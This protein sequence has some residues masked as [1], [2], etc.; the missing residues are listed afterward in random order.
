MQRTVYGHL[1]SLC[2]W[3]ELLLDLSSLW[4]LG[5]MSGDSSHYVVVGQ[6]NRNAIVQSKKLAPFH[7]DLTR[8]NPFEPASVAPGQYTKIKL[9]MKHSTDRELILNDI[10][11][12][13]N[14]DFSARTTASVGNVF[15][16]RGT[17]LIREL[18]VKI[19]EDI[20]FKVDRKGD[21]TL[22]WLMNNH[23]HGGEEEAVN[24]S[25]LMNQGVIPAGYS[26][27]FFYKTADSGWYTDAA[28]TTQTLTLAEVTRPGLERHD[29]LPRLI[30][31]DQDSGN[32]YKFCFDM[33][34]NQLCGPIFNRLHL[35]RVEFIQIELM[36]EPW[37]SAG[38]TQDFLLFQKN[39]TPSGSVHPYSVVRFENLEIR[40]YRTTLLDGV[41]GFTLPPSR[42]LSWLMHRYTRRDYSFNFTTGSTLDIKLNDFEVRSNIVRIWWMLAPLNPQSTGNGFAPLAA[43]CEPYESLFGV[44]I[45]W[46]NDKVLDLDTVPQV[47]RHYVLSDNKRYSLSNP[48]KRFNRL[49]HREAPTRVTDNNRINYVW[50]EEARDSNV[51]GRESY[52]VPIYHVDL[53]MNI[54][55]G[56]PGAEILG[57]IVN[58]TADYVIR[59][60]RPYKD[61]G[62]KVSNNLMAFQHSGE[63]TI[64]VWLEY[65]TLVNLAAGSNQFQRGSQIV[66]KQLNVQ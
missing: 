13:F 5:T 35:R 64:Y 56:V 20:V 2:W 45:L 1:R 9:D 37:V 31:S 3:L 59:L 39:P 63:R 46:K 17:D 29:G 62:A 54:H 43:P 33:S 58:D 7:E 42:M 18:V 36:F 21:L 10:R 16:V 57:G 50:N 27:S 61:E 24:N 15:A 38:M 19:N 14:V 55:Q 11:L 53:S 23:K 52:E 65:Q 41:T 30:Y 12:R 60:K 8:R 6:N 4:E 22:L 49:M 51:I 25:Y 34:L 26:P 66:T 47:W 48:H 44:E 40:Q 28:L 32:I